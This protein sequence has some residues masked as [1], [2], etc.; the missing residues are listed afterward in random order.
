MND[1]LHLTRLLQATA[2]TLL[3]AS[4]TITLASSARP[5]ARVTEGSPAPDST[6]SETASSASRNEPG[7]ATAPRD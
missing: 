4:S 3:A 1:N 7:W 2:S 5:A 6:A